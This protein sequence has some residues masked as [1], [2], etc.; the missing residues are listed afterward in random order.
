MSLDMTYFEH[1]GNHYVIW[2]DIIGQSALY[3][4]Q[5]DPAQP[6]AGTGNVIQLTTPE[7]GWERDT[8]RVNEGPTILKHDGKI[9]CAFSAS[10][11]GP[12]YCIGMLY[13][14]ENAN[15]MDKNS[16]TKMNYPLLTSSDVPGEYGP[17]HNSFTVDAGGNPI[18]VYH[19]RSEECYNNQ[20]Q[21]ASASS[22]YD[23]CRHARV[24]N[25]H[26]TEDGFPILK[27]S[28]EEECP[29]SMR[30][31]SVQVTVEKDTGKKL[32]EVTV[33]EIEEMEATKEQLRPTITVTY[34][35]TV[36]TESR[37]YVLEYGEN[38]LAGKGTV[39]IK[40]AVDS[41]Y[42]GSKTVE[43]DIVNPAVEVVHYDMSRD[44]EK[45]KDVSNN[46]HIAAVTDLKD[47]NFNGYK[48]VN[49]LTLNKDGYIS[50][51][52]GIVTDNTLT[53]NVTAATT[54]SNNQWLWAIGK[55]SWNYAFLTPSNNA[56]KTK[57]AVAQ[58][59]RYDTSGAWASEK[60][61]LTDAKALD[62]KYQTYTL[63]IDDKKTVMYV[64]GEKV[65]EGEN[66]YDITSFID[67]LDVSGYIGKSLYSGDPLFV[68]QVADFTI[69]DDALT[70]KQ[71]QKI[72]DAVDY[73]GYI[74]A[75]IYGKMLKNNTSADDVKTDLS[76]PAKVDG[77]EV[78]WN[79]P[80]DQT[81]ISDSGKV[82][83]PTDGKDAKAAVTASYEWNGE[84]ISETFDLTVASQNLNE[85]ADK[86]SLPYSTESG[87]E[88][89]GNI[90]LPK[91][92]EN[93]DI[94]WETDHP[95][96]V[97]LKEYVNT[98]VY[99][100]DP[101][102]AGQVTRPAKDT[103]VTMTA[104][105]K[106][107]NQ[108][109]TKELTFMVKAAPEEIKESDYTDYFFAYFV[110]QN[111]ADQEQIYFSASQD[112]LN[113][114]DLNNNRPYLT[115]ILGERGV[116]DPFIL[117]SHEGDKF[118]LIATDLSIYYNGDWGRAQNAGSNSLM[119]WESTDLV[120]WSDQ[121]MIEVSSAIGA[122]CTWAPEATYDEETGEYVV[123]W[124]SK[125]PDDNYSKQR[126]WCAKT[127]DFYSF[128]EPKV[129]IDN[130]D[131]TI[132]TTILKEN[133]WYYRYSK[134]EKAKNIIAEKTQT[135][136]H[137]NAISISTPVLG[138]QGGVEGP[139]IFKFNEDDIEANGAKYCLLLDNYGGGGYY[140]MLSSNLEGDF[141]RLT[142]GYKLPGSGKTPRHG[143]PMRITAAEYQRVMAAMA[144]TA[145]P[146]PTVPDTTPTPSV[147][148]TTP[149][150]SV[151][152]VTP[153]P[154]VG[155]DVTLTPE[156][157]SKDD[158]L[159]INVPEVS[160]G[161]KDD[162]T[163]VTVYVGKDKLSDQIKDSADKDIT[164]NVKV[165]ASVT[166][167]ENVNLE[168][169]ILP[170]EVLK[171]VKN[172]GKNLSVKVDSINGQSYEVA[173]DSADISTAKLANVNFLLLIDNAK[174]DNETK[175]K[176]Y[177]DESGMTVDFAHRTDLPG[178]FSIKVD[179]KKMGFKEGE[180]V[181][182]R[183]FTADNRMADD[184]Q[185][186]VVDAD[187]KITFKTAEGRKYILT[188][189]TPIAVG[190]V[191][192]T[193]EKS[194]ATKVIL[195]WKKVEGA[196]GYR[197]YRY[198]SKTKKY[199]R[200]AQVKTN[201][202]VDTKRATATA[203]IYKIRAVVRGSKYYYGAY[204]SKIK[205]LTRPTKLKIEGKRTSPANKSTTATISFR[206]VPRATAYRIYKYSKKEQ[207][208]LA[209]YQIKKGYLYKYN[210]KTLKF[211]KKNK[212]KVQN[213]KV[214]CTLTGLNLKKEKAQKF[215]ARSI[216]T[217]RGY[218]TQFSYTSNE[219]TIK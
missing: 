46:S 111:A 2:A 120:H 9:F 112:G 178:T 51:P 164:V 4:Q 128:T 141:T 166:G 181:R 81:V 161:T 29:T 147:P 217:K 146:T 116:R 48:G 66:P 27:M 152:D 40:P 62:G 14:D 122:G 199:E 74:T 158:S 188:K 21:W 216:T 184:T 12:E 31:V 103:V 219:I 129:M 156:A 45:I 19:A 5:I 96:I 34:K 210:S 20:C 209:A 43:F 190:D 105:L 167:T 58:H 197:V 163:N 131:T 28:A 98:G 76:F 182:V 171:A 78:T 100:D 60:S 32:S 38:K 108:E 133:G 64:N 72:A 140:P 49:T 87:K 149:T 130:P 134:N 170:K 3:M 54:Q 33:S 135:L 205:V 123:Y 175:D 215:T 99:A 73:K 118:Y 88:V 211:D 214:T 50:L 187:G 203:Q 82:V 154:S 213:G 93:V 195:T 18:F 180:E 65:G 183:Y 35:G 142:S 41:D 124:A 114:K 104:T 107:G 79:I 201:S 36:L 109:A 110:G 137:S 86:L 106:S 53:I 145:T 155:G 144:G 138:S 212:V 6:W 200:L 126:I 11:T 121:R 174:K 47:T 55:D 150:P 159:T 193:K 169:L 191:K 102:P 52:K 162:P 10:G 186:C 90:T 160:P 89:Y 113:W 77:I 24:K 196:D 185:T 117:R 68:G 125:T 148:D 177:V 218:K 139:S 16:W 15:L 70:A 26:W 71:V 22:L 85:L 172:N 17:G 63:T 179:G 194:T 176:L 92:I 204:T 127:R 59:E 157:E 57:F 61:I 30:N 97:D 39:T 168:S 56:S 192:E 44:G 151:P 115:S 94:T 119:V 25:V 91:S 84:Q 1:N 7:F 153:T 206:K 75:D 83:R 208:Y 165:P 37:D 80:A 143:T 173:V 42:I 136:L 101:T 132:D 95:E 67:G 189:T 202:Y 69:Y 207:K 13:A 198:N 8:E 23:P